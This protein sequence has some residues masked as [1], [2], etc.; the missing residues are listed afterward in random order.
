MDGR[1]TIP[2]IEKEIQEI[3]KDGW[4]CRDDLKKL[5]LLGEAM[6]LLGHT[7]REFTESDARTWV[8]HM[9]PPGK[10]TMEQTTAVMRQH[11]YDHRPCVFYA[12]MNMLWSDYGKTVNKFGMDRADFWAEMA[13]D[14]INDPDAED[15]KVG[16][17]WRDIVKK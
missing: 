17:Y 15:M 12:I 8:S 16:R 2:N 9:D 3:L 14:W 1:I 10:W 5:V 4:M 13:N 11:G 7:D 6:D